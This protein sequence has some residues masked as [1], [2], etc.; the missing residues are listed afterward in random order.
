MSNNKTFKEFLIE[1]DSVDLAWA[2]ELKDEERTKQQSQAEKTQGADEIT[3]KYGMSPSVND[4][5]K[6]N[7][8]KFLITK[9][10]MDGMRVK[11]LGSNKMG[12]VPHG[13]KF[14]V[15]GTTGA[16]GKEFVIVK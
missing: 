6:T 13:T 11:Q 16:G 14:K 1:I 15:S 8:G 9:M 2:R 12:T 4:V 10:G 3:A 5:I 7:S